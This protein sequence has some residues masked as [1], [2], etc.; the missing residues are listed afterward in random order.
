M[1]IRLQPRRDERAALAFED[2]ASAIDAGLPPAM[3]GGDPAAGDRFLPGLF[4]RKQIDLDPGEN[5]VLIAAWRS[6][7]APDALKHLARQRRQRAEFARPLITSLRYPT[8]LVSVALLVSIF[9]R[10]LPGLHALPYWIAACVALGA[11][12]LGYVLRALGQGSPWL[13]RIPLAGD[14]ASSLAE[15]SYLEVMRGLYSAGVPLLEAHPQATATCPVAAVREGLQ[16]ANGIL[17]QGR[18]L[19]EALH[20]T[21]ALHPE[22]LHLL[23]TGERAGNLEDALLR[24]LSRR[25][26]VASQSAAQLSRL[27][28]AACYTFGCLIAV[29]VIFSV[30]GGYGA[31]LRG[32]L[33]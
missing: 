23:A 18:P 9:V 7:R 2:V 31:M 32:V 25:Q 10:A 11:L 27:L 21:Q 30:Y 22:T 29:Y 1:L 17:Q 33:R 8:L 4:A 12:G 3:L 16:Q 20:Q 28:G 5:L 6:G 24:A 19:A 14:V 15:L 26:A 13:L